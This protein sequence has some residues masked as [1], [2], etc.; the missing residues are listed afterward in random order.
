MT[1]FY[2]DDMLSN[3]SR[4]LT[5]TY[6][7]CSTP[8]TGSTLLCSLL[9]A[10]GVA[11]IPQSYFRKQDLRRWAK[12]WGISSENGIFD[13]NEYVRAAIRAGQSD[14]GI[15]AARIMWETLDEL[16]RELRAASSD[17]KDSELIEQTFGRT[18]FLHIRR[19]DVVAQ[20]VSR[21]IAEQTQVWHQLES[22]PQMAAKNSPD[23]DFIALQL[24][25]QEAKEHL[26]AWEDW[27][28]L[29][30]LHPYKISYAQ[31]DENPVSV[32]SGV[33]EFL[34]LELPELVSIQAP[35]KRLANEV[36]EQWIARYHAE[37]QST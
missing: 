31:I 35:N 27:F 37:S 9:K 12:L 34:G 28:R 1:L 11:G 25:V 24:H 19:D 15:F 5:H 4:N 13:F 17:V 23:Y 2:L 10:T 16:M 32:I 30:D 22:K 33:L 8:R 6:L 29:N 26:Q 18:K 14:N 21:L 7:I 36:N 3:M 20:A